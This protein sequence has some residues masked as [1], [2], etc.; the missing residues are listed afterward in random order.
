[1]LSAMRARLVLAL[2]CLLG[3]RRATPPAEA[4][5]AGAVRPD[6]PRPSSVMG[7]VEVS[8]PAAFARELG[9][10]FG[11][12]APVE[13]L[14]GVALDVE[15]SR[16]AA[17]DL[18]KPAHLALTSEGL[19]VALRSGA[20]SATEQALAGRW[21]MEEEP[22]LG[23]WIVRDGDAARA[24]PCVLLARSPEEG[25]VV[26]GP[27][28]AAV[29]A[30][31]PW[32]ARRPAE[33]R[34]AALTGAMRDDALARVALPSLAMAL[35]AWCDWLDERAAQ[36]RAT[37]GAPTYGDPEPLVRR[38]RGWSSDI[39]GAGESL[40]DARV[41]A[42]FEGGA[43]RLSV[44]AAVRPEAVDALA[45]LTRWG[46]DHPA[47]LAVR[48]P[49]IGWGASLR[50]PD[51]RASATW[52]D[53]SGLALDVLGA[54]VSDRSAVER[55]FAQL[56]ASLRGR[57]SISGS[58]G[59]ERSGLELSLDAQETLLRASISPLASAPWWR[60]VRVGGAVRAR[61]T[62]EGID[63]SAE[64]GGALSL[65]ARGGA[66]VVRAG[67]AVDG[68]QDHVE[69]AL[70]G[71]VLRLG[72]ASDPALRVWVRAS[73]GTSGPELVLDL[74]AGRVALRALPALLEE[75][76]ESR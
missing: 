73:R 49:R 20:A 56:G 8:E 19:V 25:R 42:G 34:G 72:A 10:A 46:A 48:A 63:V 40:R 23:A 31:A 62:T 7:L 16:L 37:R 33:A 47:A 9:E 58:F 75:R 26:C 44:R 27:S 53:V 6:P 29:R 61:R 28:R 57:W 2:L 18:T 68:A 32:L 30:V 60:G 67:A 36:A 38:I 70:A 74:H 21:R 1:M 66:L 71:A 17:A 22:D 4:R 5:P 43:L 15:P 12:D 3:C 59:G 35:R 54:R 39:E 65:L 52:R 13:A 51:E 55:S 69:D 64:G 11:L 50:L 45:T 14:V 41:S 24:R 76:S